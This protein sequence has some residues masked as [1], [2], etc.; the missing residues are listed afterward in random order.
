MTKHASESLSIS[1]ATR[2]M[3][4]DLNRAEQGGESAAFRPLLF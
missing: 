2:R 3:G 4:R 1:L